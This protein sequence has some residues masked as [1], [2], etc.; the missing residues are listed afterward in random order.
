MD[1]FAPDDFCVDK[2]RLTTLKVYFD[3]YTVLLYNA[4]NI[5]KI[6]IVQGHLFRPVVPANQFNDANQPVNCFKQFCLTL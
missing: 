3:T 4:V 6:H 2:L 1:E 5:Q